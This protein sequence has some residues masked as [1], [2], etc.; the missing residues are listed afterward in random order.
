[1]GWKASC[2]LIN[3][4][5]PGYLGSLPEH[6][7]EAA[8]QLI[9][10]LRL[11][12][13]LSKGITSFDEGIFPRHLVVGAYEG[14]AVL[15]APTIADDCFSLGD[16]PVMR[17]VIDRF[18]EAEVA[19][20]GLHSV[21]NFWSYE[22]FDHG[23]LLRAYGGSAD[24]GVVVDLGNLLPEERPHFERS[25]IRDGER[26]FITEF[27]GVTEEYDPSSYGEELVFELMGRFFGRN[28]AQWSGEDNPYSLV[29][30][31]FDRLQ[32]PRWW[33]PFSKP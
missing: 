10:D 24:D 27:N 5:E 17:R 3:D 21:V 16:D 22:F 28:M 33:W 12:P 11:G 23:R 25:I 31:G 32:P 2:I 4:R 9:D 14:A 30:E 18:P 20:F 19:R 1:M 6:D 13:V 29:M 8:R 7:P 26:V 15:G